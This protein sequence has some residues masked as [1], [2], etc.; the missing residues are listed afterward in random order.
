MFNMTA[1]QS[2]QS[3]CAPARKPSD[4]SVSDE[5]SQMSMKKG[6]TEGMILLKGGDFLMGSNDKTFPAD[7]EGPVRQ[8]Q[9]RPFWIEPTAVSN[10]QFLEFVEATDYKTEA[11]RFGWSFVFH[12]FLPEDHPPTRA[13]Q[14]APWWRQVHDADW[15]H[16]EGPHS[17]LEDRLNHPV[18]HV[19]WH[20]ATAYAQW[21]GKRLLTEAEWEYAARG[22]LKQKRFPWGNKLE[23]GGKHHCNVWQGNFPVKNTTEDGYL[24]TAPVDAFKPNKFGLYNMSGNVWE[25]CADWFSPTYHRKASRNNPTGPK[26]GYSKV[27]RGGSYLCHESYCNRYRVSARTSN[28]PDSSTGHMG[29]RL[30]LNVT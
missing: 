10:A 21:A 22:G 16:P 30:A 8:V 28:T 2:T 29:F 5:S 7:G 15:R 11:E 4:R 20:D 23:Q 25:W 26:E 18:T 27:M 13:V 9:V 14:Q 12:L 3:C 6:S 19:S 1:K 24:S 17:S